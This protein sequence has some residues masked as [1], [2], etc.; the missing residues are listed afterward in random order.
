LTFLLAAAVAALLILDVTDG[1]VGWTSGVLLVVLGCLGVYGVTERRRGDRR[2]TAR[3]ARLCA[4]NLCICPG[5]VQ[6]FRERVSM[7]MA[8]GRCGV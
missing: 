2:R 3:S 6:R 5:H 4:K 1:D 7:A 8:K